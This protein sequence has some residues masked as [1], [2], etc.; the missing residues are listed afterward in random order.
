M[1]IKV[2]VT[3]LFQ[4]QVTD[5][6]N[7]YNFN[8]INASGNLYTFPEGQKA[9][10]YKQVKQHLHTGHTSAWFNPTKW[11]VQGCQRR[12]STAPHRL[13]HHQQGGLLKH[14][15]SPKHG[16]C[17]LFHLRKHHAHLHTNPR[18][19]TSTEL[20]QEKKKK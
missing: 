20:D 19:K 3:N 7:R 4:S 6:E 18:H 14:V 9:T 15:R 8:I 13:L 10:N 5:S 11:Q 2:V 17:P 12:L 16:P 1:C